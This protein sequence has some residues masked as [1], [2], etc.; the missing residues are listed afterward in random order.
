MVTNRYAGR[1]VGAKTARRNG[2][3]M[4]RLIVLDNIVVFVRTR[5]QRLESGMGEALGAIVGDRP[6]KGPNS[7]E[8]SAWPLRLY[9]SQ[10]SRELSR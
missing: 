4:L 3:A 1:G 5:E 9:F 7:C 6:L 2:D 8:L 10:P